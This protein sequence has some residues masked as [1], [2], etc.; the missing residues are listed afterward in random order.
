MS[1]NGRIRLARIP[2][3]QLPGRFL[4]ADESFPGL[5]APV[6]DRRCRRRPSRTPSLAP[7]DSLILPAIQV[8][9][10]VVTTLVL[11]LC[12]AFVALSP[13]KNGPLSP[14]LFIAF[15]ASLLLA[16]Q[17]IHAKIIR[18]ESFPRRRESTNDWIPDQVRYD[19]VAMFSCHSNNILIERISITVLKATTRK[20]HRDLDCF[21]NF[22]S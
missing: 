6:A 8:F 21:I 4:L 10:A 13:F 5:D 1:D 3:I 14:L 18:P 17:T 12:L 19:M 7:Q 11:F 15:A 2:N 22:I 20:N 16:L 9:F